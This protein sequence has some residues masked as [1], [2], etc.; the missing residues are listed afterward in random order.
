MAFG[1]EEQ[2][3]VFVVTVAV[4]VL[5]VNEEEATRDATGVSHSESKV[6]KGSIKENPIQVLWTGMFRTVRV[7][8][9]H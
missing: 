2:E 9:L 5:V 8:E 3:G 7:S 4:V 6:S 1:S